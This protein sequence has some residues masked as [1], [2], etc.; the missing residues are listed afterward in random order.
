MPLSD[1]LNSLEKTVSQLACLSSPPLSPTLPNGDPSPNFTKLLG[2]PHCRALLL[3][4]QL[5][6]ELEAHAVPK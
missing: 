6:K 5:R 1:E 2:C 3:V 4:A